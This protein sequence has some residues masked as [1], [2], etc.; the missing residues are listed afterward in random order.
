[1]YVIILV[2]PV[3]PRAELPLPRST[4]IPR[5]PPLLT[6]EYH[7]TPPQD[8]GNTT[9]SPPSPP[10]LCRPGGGGRGIPVVLG[11]SARGNTTTPAPWFSRPPSSLL[12]DPSFCPRT[13]AGISGWTSAGYPAP[14]L[15]LWAASSFLIRLYAI[16]HAYLSCETITSKV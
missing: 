2:L 12:I 4:G 3:F 13:S 9:T 8:R 16:S 5:P 11:T 6:R 1:M 15:T 7:D 14:E 10:N